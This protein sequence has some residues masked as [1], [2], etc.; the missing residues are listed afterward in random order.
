MGIVL[1]GG[2]TFLSFSTAIPNVKLIFSFKK[3][4]TKKGGF[5]LTLHRKKIALK[6]FNKFLFNLGNFAV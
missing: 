3:P 2:L 6:L 1:F 5:P 4:K